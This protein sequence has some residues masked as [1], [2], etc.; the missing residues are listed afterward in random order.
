MGSLNKRF[1]LYMKLIGL[2]PAA[3]RKEY[4]EQILQTTADMLDNTP[5]ALGKMA[6]WL[7]IAAD[8]PLNVCKQQLQYAGTVMHNE[9]PTY[10]KRSSLVSVLLLAPF[11]IALVANAL[12]K[13][14]NNR[15]LY[16]LWLL[17]FPLLKVWVLYFPIIALLLAVGSYITFI[18]HQQQ[19]S[20]IHR[21]L[22][23][24]RT[25]L[26]IVPA[27][28]AFDILFT[29]VFH[30]SIQCWTSSPSHALTHLAQAWQCSEQ[31]SALKV[32]TK[33]F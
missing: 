11:V 12:D 5:T 1:P 10:V 28:L 27:I 7:R 26:V 6:I 30:D 24:R 32:F 29:I 18:T 9:T 21:C 22:D 3:Y 4:A 16:G 31:N 23:I 13:A 19:Q 20:L 8:L 14:I 33:S 15:P 17:R 2:Y 25:W